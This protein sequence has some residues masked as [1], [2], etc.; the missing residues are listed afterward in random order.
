MGPFVKTNLIVSSRGQLTLPAEIRK[1]YGINE[2]SI[3]VAEDRNGEIILRP[4][5]VMEVE[6]YTDT[7]IKEWVAAD[8]FKN[9]RERNEMRSKLRKFSKAK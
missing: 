5:T 7:Q 1:K 2:G 4:A 9:D 3:L 6:Y 8:S